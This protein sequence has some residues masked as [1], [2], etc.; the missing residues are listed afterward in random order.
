MSRRHIARGY[1]WGCMS[2]TE[3]PDEDDYEDETL[4]C[5]EADSGPAEQE[6]EPD[7]TERERWADAACDRWERDTDRRHGA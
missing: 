3:P 5:Q 2:N 1:V 6:D 7:A 4:G